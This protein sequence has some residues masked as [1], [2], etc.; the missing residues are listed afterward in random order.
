[1]QYVLHPAN[2]LQFLLTDTTIAPLD[3]T[4]SVSVVFPVA[5]ALQTENLKY[6]EQTTVFNTEHRARFIVAS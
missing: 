6:R 5:F 3:N 4:R 2:L 1:M